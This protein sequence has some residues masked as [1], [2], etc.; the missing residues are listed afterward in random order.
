MDSESISISIA[1]LKGVITGKTYDVVAG[2]HG[3]TRTAVERR[4]KALALK[5]C[6]EV[7]IEGLNQDGL[8]FVQR[9]R[10]CSEGVTAALERYTPNLS[11][12]RP[13]RRIL[14]DEEIGLAVQRTRVRSSC[15]HRDIA[16]LYILLSTGARPLEIARLEVCDYLDF[17]G[18]VREQSAMRAEV[19]IN[20]KAR[21]LFFASSKVAESI[22]SYLAER[23]RRG[24][25][26]ADPSCYR[27]LDPHSRLFLTET[28]A[29]FDIVSYGEAGQTRFLCR[30]ILDTYRKIFRRI[31]L[32]G[33]SAL[34]VRRAV[35]ARLLERGAAEDQIGEV[36][37]ISELKSV[38]ELLP[39]VRRPLHLVVR[40]LV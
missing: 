33:L 16:L 14:T 22:D 31:G 27:G 20:N 9:L 25:A 7:G 17:G 38:R 2:E 19:A 34:N 1:M 37:G 21:P 10:K 26:V 39:D 6:Q 28:G 11:H 35:A 18:N 12:E 29:A 13:A 3:V 5:L 8:A 30:G 40:E 32:E 4:I 15:P 24:Y 36:L 23:L